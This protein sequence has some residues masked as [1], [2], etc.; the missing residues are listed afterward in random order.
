MQQP[1]AGPSVLTA[2]SPGA[3]AASGPGAPA[4]AI[5]LTL[6]ADLRRRWRPLLALALLLGL[7]GGVVLT[8][9]A[10]ARRTDTAYPRLLASANASQVSIVPQG[11]GMNGY[12]TALAKLPQVESMAVGQ[13]YQAA[14][15]ADEQTPVQL[16]VSPDGRYGTQVDRVRVLAGHLLNEG[17]AGQAMVNQAMAAAEHLTP[18]DTVR[19]LG[20]PND[21]AGTADYGKAVTFTFHVTAIVALDPQMDLQSGGYGAPAVLV[22]A[23]FAPAPLASAMS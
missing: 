14:L 9:A 17:V 12:Y 18:G 10:G 5:W 22:S 13:L 2:Y 3:P 23:P 6:R 11:T 8:A 16:I 1:P 21:Q 7:L 4:A 19:V 20:I 15:P